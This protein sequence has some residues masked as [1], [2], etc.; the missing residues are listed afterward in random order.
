MLPARC[1]C[2]VGADRCRDWRCGKDF[3][4]LTRSPMSMESG[5]PTPFVPPT[6]W[7]A[8]DRWSMRWSPSMR[9]ATRARLRRTTSCGSAIEGWVRAVASGCREWRG[10]RTRRPSHLWSPGSGWRSSAPGCRRR[11]CSIPSGRTASTWP[12][13]D[14]GSAWST[15]VGSISPRTGR[16][17]IWSGGLSRPGGLAGRAVRLGGGVSPAGPGGRAGASEDRHDDHVSVPERTMRHSPRRSCSRAGG[18]R[19]GGGSAQV[20]RWPT[21]RSA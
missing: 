6:T 21:M 18:A 3:W 5:S 14:G 17:G 1:S 8:G 2:R 16:G 15:T 19:A 11:W 4:V 20:S 12:T 13:R 7:L 9:S 10:W